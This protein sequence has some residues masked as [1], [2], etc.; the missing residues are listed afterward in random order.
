M[1]Q[2]LPCLSLWAGCLDWAPGVT[3]LLV[4]LAMF[5]VS[6]YSLSVCFLLQKGVMLRDWV[7]IS[8][9]GWSVLLHGLFPA[10]VEKASP[11]C[12]SCLQEPQRTVIY[13]PLLLAY[14]D[15]VISD[16]LTLHL[17]PEV[18]FVSTQ[19]L[20]SYPLISCIST[21]SK[22]DVS[23]RGH[24]S[25]VLGA[26]SSYSRLAACLLMQP[27]ADGSLCS[28]CSWSLCIFLGFP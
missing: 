12:C 21:S 20:A 9:A 24:S 18:G 11:S 1:P 13:S 23:S 8:T 16:W 27:T 6:I 7:L 22:S 17:L 4:A 2:S 25:T 14:S 28:L 15:L 5:H 19:S 3:L 26:P 10:S